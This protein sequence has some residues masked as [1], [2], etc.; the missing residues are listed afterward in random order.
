MNTELEGRFSY[1]RTQETNLGNF[2]TDIM[3]EAVN[4]DC[5]ILNSGTFRSDL[6]HPTGEFKVRDLKKILPYLGQNVVISVTGKFI[7]KNNSNHF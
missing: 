6:L 7:N 2:F 4:A 1:I 5:A 3:L